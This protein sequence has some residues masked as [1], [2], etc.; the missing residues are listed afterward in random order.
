MDFVIRMLQFQP[1]SDISTYDIGPHA[2]KPRYDD[3]MIYLAE[4]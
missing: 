4:A 2:L 3:A 1:M